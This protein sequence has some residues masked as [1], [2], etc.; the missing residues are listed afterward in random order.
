MVALTVA[1]AVRALRAA[2]LPAGRDVLVHASMRAV[3]PLADGPTTV[4]AAIREVIGRGA[5][6]VV[7]AQTPI[8]S[9][10]SRA[11]AE[12]TRNMSAAELA[13]FASRLEGFDP[14]SSPAQ[15]MGA[16]A[17]TVRQHPRAHR[18]VHPLTSFA[19]LGGRAQRLMAQ[20]DIT[21]LLGEQSPLR[22]LYDSHATVLLLGVDFT[23]CT[24][25]HL[26]E[27]RLPWSA[28]TQRYRCF[29]RSSGGRTECEFTGARYDDG[30]F[31]DLGEALD[32]QPFV[33]HGRLGRAPVRVLPMR[34]T[35]D[36]SA[37]WMALHRCPASAGTQEF[38]T[39]S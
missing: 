18:S 35:V 7:P 6:I 3:G 37:I 17:E 30:D 22:A 23:A 8:H 28:P 25:I 38:M 1:E 26:A 24:A 31:A 15:G 27:H 9:P 14:G 5:A 11:F 4:V 29:V 34:Q 12:A 33:G 32:I 20:H 36:F 39:V 16:L 13:R 2:A 19:A 10:T 21:S